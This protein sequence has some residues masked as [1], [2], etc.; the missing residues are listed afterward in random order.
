MKLE[1]ARTGAKVGAVPQPPSFGSG[2]KPLLLTSYHR[3]YHYLQ[4][5]DL[6]A[7]LINDCVAHLS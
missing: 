4:R 5:R 6:T 1:S 3:G 7:R 2:L